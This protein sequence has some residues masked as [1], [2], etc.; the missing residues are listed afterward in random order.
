MVCYDLNVVFTAE[1]A[2]NA[3]TL[4]FHLPVIL[5][6]TGGQ[7]GRQMQIRMHSV[8]YFS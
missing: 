6:N 1:L 3:E 5:Q 7:E 2:E 4:F 8:L